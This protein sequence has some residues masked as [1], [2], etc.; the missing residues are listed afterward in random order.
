MEVLNH[1]PNFNGV[2]M[3][4]K[5]APMNAIFRVDFRVWSLLY[6]GIVELYID[7]LVHAWSNPLA[8]ALE[9]PQDCTKPSM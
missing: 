5:G 3:L 9:L 4:I 6:F 7:G 1:S 2:A 8:N